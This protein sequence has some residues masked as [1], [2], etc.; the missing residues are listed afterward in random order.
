MGS[1]TH[2]RGVYGGEYAPTGLRLFAWWKK[3]EKKRLEKPNSGSAQKSWSNQ[4]R[5]NA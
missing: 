2:W 5:R 3:N 1:T 4:N